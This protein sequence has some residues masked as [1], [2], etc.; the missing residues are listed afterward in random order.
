MRLD[1]VRS[2]DFCPFGAR[3]ENRAASAP[4]IE[5]AL[6]RWGRSA[7]SFDLLLE[8]ERYDTFAS[9]TCPGAVVPFRRYGRVDVLMGD[10]LVPEDQLEPVA[11]EFLSARR[12]A[13]RPLLGFATSREFALACVDAGCAAVQ[14]TAEPEIDPLHYAPTGKHAKKLRSHVHK[15]ERAGVDA[16]ALPAGTAEVP[17]EFR[18]AAERLVADW[19]AHGPPREAHLLE[20]DPWVRT[21]DKRYF[22]V[23]DPAD[24]A[25][26][27]SLLIAH[28]IYGRGGWHF[29]HLIHASE[30]LRG[31]NELNVLRAVEA[32]AAEGCSYVTFG[33]FAAPS[34]GEFHGFG[35]VW[36]PLIRT[37]YDRVA[38]RAGYAD[39]LAFYEKIKAP[40][41]TPRFMVMAPRHFPLRAML[42]L[43]Q[44]THVL[45]TH[46]RHPTAGHVPSADAP[47]C[48]DSA[49]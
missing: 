44:V 33:P 14:L 10:P 27:L 12:A 16:T 2:L 28:P 4:E 35:G 8:P 36:R 1:R 41:F 15:L 9:V 3:V 48:P 34:A 19:L 29:C 18:I 32:L 13:H 39:T 7:L 47:P 5:S 37:F 30:A 21:A 49:S 26:L 24:P 20:V 45:G 40:P 42:A 22:A 25:R 46:G 6:R 23:P 17:T 31:A 43:S 38:L 11:R